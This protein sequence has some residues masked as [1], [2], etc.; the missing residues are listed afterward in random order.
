MRS[1][2]QTEKN[3]NAGLNPVFSK[4]LYGFNDSISSA[5]NW[6]HQ[7]D[8]SLINV[9]RELGIIYFGSLCLLITLNQDLSNTY[10]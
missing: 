10:D 2:E 6:I 3:D 9:W 1:G 5:E 8:F 4:N 7:K